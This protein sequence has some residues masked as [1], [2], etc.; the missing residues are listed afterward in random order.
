LEPIYYEGL[1]ADPKFIWTIKKDWYGLDEIFL[2]FNPDSIFFR[3]FQNIETFKNDYFDFY[4]QDAFTRQI[5]YIT[6]RYLN[7]KADI[8]RDYPYLSKQEMDAFVDSA[9]TNLHKIYVDIMKV[10]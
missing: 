5:H 10:L 4:P 9:I 7:T 8:D 6:N 3:V 2:H 1:K